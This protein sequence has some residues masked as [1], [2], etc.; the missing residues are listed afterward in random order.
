MNFDYQELYLDMKISYLQKIRQITQSGGVIYNYK[1]KKYG[2]A[3]IIFMEKYKNN[4]GRNEW[5]LILFKSKRGKCIFYEDLGGGIDKDDLEYDNPLK[6]TAAREAFEESRG[7]ISIEPEHITSRIN[8]K[9][10]YID[11]GKKY[12]YR[13]Y[14]IALPP[15]F[16]KSDDYLLNKSNIDK[17]KTVDHVMKETHGITRFYI[18]DLVKDGLLDDHELVARDVNNKKYVIYGRTRELIKS[19]YKQKILNNVIKFPK[20]VIKLNTV[21]TVK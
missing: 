2:G 1:N 8:N 18:K 5:A 14:F 19:A 16:I 12:S 3:G 9:N 15:K 10:T 6:N 7:L 20:N 21:I 13:G 4:K 11:L 17:N